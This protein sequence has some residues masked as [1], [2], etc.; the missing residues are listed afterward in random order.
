[1]PAHSTDDDAYSAAWPKVQDTVQHDF[2]C[3]ATSKERLC[4]VYDWHRAQAHGA[5]KEHSR[6]SASLIPSMCQASEERT[7]VWHQDPRVCLRFPVMCTSPPS[8]ARW[9]P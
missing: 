4:K 3:E 5:F 1:M 8:A 9:L 2:P 7:L 6:H